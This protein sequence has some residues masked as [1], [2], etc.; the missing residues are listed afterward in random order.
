MKK[1]TAALEFDPEGMTFIGP[2]WK[3]VIS[4]EQDGELVATYLTE[5]P[6]EVGFDELCGLIE[7]S[8]ESI[9]A[10]ELPDESGLDFDAVDRDEAEELAQTHLRPVVAALFP[11]QF[12]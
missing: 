11:C 1:Y 6:E 12:A 2:A 7:S 10:P 3:V 5:D 8:A 4:E 9:L